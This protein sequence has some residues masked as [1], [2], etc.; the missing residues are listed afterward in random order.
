MFTSLLWSSSPRFVMKASAS[1]GVGGMM[2]KPLI[3]FAKAPPD[4]RTNSK[5]RQIGQSLFST[6]ANIRFSALLKVVFSLAPRPAPH[7]NASRRHFTRL[8]GRY[9]RRMQ[10]FCWIAPQVSPVDDPCNNSDIFFPIYFRLEL[11][12]PFSRCCQLQCLSSHHYSVFT[13]WPCYVFGN[14]LPFFLSGP[15]STIVSS[16]SLLFEAPSRKHSSLPL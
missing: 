16:F 7:R 15:K 12:F 10:P 3:L 2:Q 8:F 14:K 6:R 13:F 11:L 9:S 5:K 1:N 4:A